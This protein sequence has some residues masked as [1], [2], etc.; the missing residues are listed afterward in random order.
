MEYNREYY[1][2]QLI[3]Y[4]VLR[5]V[6]KVIRLKMNFLP[7]EPTICIFAFG[8]CQD[9]P[10]WKKM[11][12]EVYGYDINPIFGE[13]AK[14]KNL[15]AYLKVKDVT[16]D[17]KPEFFTDITLCAYLFEHL[18]DNQCVQV[19][20][21]MMKH[22]PINIISLTTKDDPNYIKDPTHKNPKT[23]RDWGIMLGA[24]YKK[25]GWQRIWHQG[26]GWAFISP[27][28]SNLINE[29]QSNLNNLKERLWK[30]VRVNH[31]KV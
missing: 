25:L 30:D 6:R 3:S 5:P 10:K 29:M 28:V 22:S 31:V 20:R 19:I 16:V 12:S 14:E 17:F 23:N 4:D 8:H 24:V 1:E 13:D 15:A 27:S 11:F 2:H 18:D 7:F 26:G 9:Y 21:N